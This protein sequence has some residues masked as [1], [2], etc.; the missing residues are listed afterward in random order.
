[1]KQQT[2][3]RVKGTFIEKGQNRQSA[4][5]SKDGKESNKTIKDEH[6]VINECKIKVDIKIQHT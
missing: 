1:M 4:R 2:I 3:T 6:K 5:V